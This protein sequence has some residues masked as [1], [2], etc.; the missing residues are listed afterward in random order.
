MKNNIKKLALLVS[1]LFTL[2]F[3][4]SAQAPGFDDD[5]DDVPLDGGISLLVGAGVAY[6][7]KK[8]YDSRKSSK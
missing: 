1:V 8:V 2:T 3:A 4:A 5:V 7:M 6:G